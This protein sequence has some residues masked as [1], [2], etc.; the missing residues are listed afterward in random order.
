MTQ[1]IPRRP[2]GERIRRTVPELA[3]RMTQLVVDNPW[4]VALLLAGAITVTT[5]ARNIVRPRTALEALALAAV[6]EAGCVYG[7]GY[8]ITAGVIPFRVRD[9]HGE[10]VP[11]AEHARCA[12]PA[13]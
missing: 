12:D 6:L 9:E 2:R 11:A 1:D 3:A 8:V 13:A 5:A 10:L 4:Q 7:T